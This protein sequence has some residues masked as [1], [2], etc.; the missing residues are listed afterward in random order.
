MRLCQL[1]VLVTALTCAA[2]PVKALDEA[3]EHQA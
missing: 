3:Y 2:A 1:F